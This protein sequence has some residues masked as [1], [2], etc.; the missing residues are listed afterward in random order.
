VSV[1][2]NIAVNIGNATG[3]PNITGT[4][5]FGS[6]LTGQIC[7]TNGLTG[8][9]FYYQLIAVDSNEI[10]IGGETNCARRKLVESEA[11]N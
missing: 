5:T 6:L 3:K 2:N 7:D 10:D 8:V 4:A 9:A 1:T 11:A